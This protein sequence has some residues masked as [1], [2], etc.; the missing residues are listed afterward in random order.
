MT[1][2]SIPARSVPAA[3]QAA[4]ARATDPAASAWVTA[5]AGA[6]KTYVLARR[7]IHLLLDGADPATIL[8]LT[9]T[10]AAAAEMAQRVFGSLAEWATMPQDKLA[11][12]L[13]EFGDAPV[14]GARIAAARRLFASA[15]E[16]PG[17]LKIQTIHAFCERLL[18]Q[19]PFEAN[20]PGQ[21][22]VLDDLTGAELLAEARAATLV[23]TTDEHGTLGQAWRMLIGAYT[24]SRIDD[25]L[26]E[27]VARRYKLRQWIVHSGGEPG[28]G[29]VDSAI[30]QL[31]GRLGL[32]ESEDADS[33][34]GDFR[35]TAPIQ[36]AD[37]LRLLDAL[38][39]NSSV[40][41]D[42]AV[43]IVETI[44]TAG[45]PRSEYEARCAFALKAD[46]E[47]RV[48]KSRVSKPVAT[49]LPDFESVFEREAEALLA[50]RDKLNAVRTAGLT[51]ALLTVFDAILTH[52]EAAKARRGL[53]DF[54]DLIQKT[55]SLLLRAD[56]AQWVLYKLDRGL[57]HILVDEA[58]DTNP[59][60]W[61]V[62][63]ALAGEFFAGEPERRKPR[64]IFAVGDE[65]Q[66]I[67]S[68][69][70][71]DPR[72]LQAMRR[73]F[74]DKAAG[75]DQSFHATPLRLSFRSAP[76]ILKIVDQ[77]FDRDDLRASIAGDP[78][79]PVVHEAW[80]GDLAGRVEIWPRTR[81]M[82]SEE[83]DAW[84][85]PQDAPGSGTL[86]LAG[87]IAGEIER[88]RSGEIRL[89]GG[90]ASMGGIIVLVRKRGAFA[91]AM[92]AELKHRGLPAAGADRIALSSHIAVLDCLAL[93]DVVLLPQ[94]D[95]ALAALLK[96]PLVGLDEDD[97][98][99]LA[100]GRAGS[101]WVALEASDDPRHRQAFELL[102][103]WRAGADRMTPMT[104][105]A[106]V[107]GPDG[108]R[109][110]FRARLGGEADEVIDTFLSE[111]LSYE[112]GHTP[113]LQGFLAHIRASQG[114]IKRESHD[115]ADA[116]RVMTVHGAKGLEADIVFLVDDGGKVVNETMRP[117]LL[118]VADPAGTDIAPVHLLRQARAFQTAAQAAAIARHDKDQVD[119]YRRLLYV[120]MT[121]ARERLYLTGIAKPRTPPD[122]W[123]GLVRSALAPD[124]L[125]GDD[126]ELAEPLV[127]GEGATGPLRDEETPERHGKPATPDWSSRPVPP[128]PR[129]PAPLRPSRALAEPDPPD[130]DAIIGLSGLPDAT[131]ALARGRLVHAL[132]ERLPALPSAD[133][134]AAAD[135]IVS[136]E[137]GL[138]TGER[139]AII[140]EAFAVLDDPEL[141]VLF[142]SQSRAEVA[143]AGSLATPAG[144]FAVGGRIDRI[145]MTG[146]SVLVADFK[147]NRQMP[148][149]PEDVDPAYV[150]QMALYR[151]LLAESLADS[152]SGRPLRALLVWTAG[153]QIMAV[154]D[155]LMDAALVARG[156]GDAFPV[157]GA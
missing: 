16:T 154:P 113:S 8:C 141:A 128:A 27:V 9:F 42:K 155:A 145:A 90:R 112:R 65:K 39:R 140:D 86:E 83:P 14:D 106:R 13:A 47:P 126:D 150:L 19:F 69:Q 10:K 3:T 22:E 144:A 46:G 99:K 41:N 98:F 28:E 124:D 76:A 142:G 62:I 7:V 5:N 120:G 77:V 104:F 71:A 153:P 122:G 59:Q 54:D 93:G 100:H 64:T 133:R 92:N 31:R 123:Y 61:N 119:E 85:T 138:E 12:A 51:G 24:D 127:F 116:V 66:S 4:Q 30:A 101:L 89:T 108:G 91:A 25:A 57:D 139:A 11:A 75:A 81:D 74:Q 87:R 17:G 56:A 129:P 38:T 149:Q 37:W 131:I 109:R 136:G 147:T 110:R 53:L 157:T 60:Q 94:N 15:L 102:S 115:S 135:I 49:E 105:F 117:Y 21:F 43:V 132:L 70:G 82:E 2:P 151:R 111:A 1:A 55:A 73:H 34:L 52:Y 18:Q 114:D 88:Y 29:S 97:L 103:R 137:S 78:A 45:D 143:I 121:R 6:G 33:L 156:L 32:G 130:P 148:A 118:P 68:F 84:E 72:E 58:Q 26:N 48:W 67:F 125:E 20:V 134:R 146:E 152:L 40:N 36:D 23:K 35:A 107:L 96:S 44:M 95:L 50:L 79:K 80:K 63:A